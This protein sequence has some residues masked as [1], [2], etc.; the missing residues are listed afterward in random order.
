[1]H[2]LRACMAG[3]RGLRGLQSRF[4]ASSSIFTVPLFRSSDIAL[5]SGTALQKAWALY[6]A[7][8]QRF[9]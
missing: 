8:A 1:M 5:P 4:A 9:T 3:L 7:S 6:S 2:A